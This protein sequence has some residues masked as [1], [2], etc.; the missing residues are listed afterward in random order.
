VYFEDRRRLGELFQLEVG[1]VSCDDKIDIVT[2]PFSSTAGELLSA[3]PAADAT[4]GGLAPLAGPDATIS[5][6]R[7]FTYPLVVRAGLRSARSVILLFHGLNEKSW[8]KYLPWAKEL[9]LRT[10]K[11]V[12]LFPIAFHMNR[13]PGEWSNPRLMARVA[14]ERQRRFGPLTDSSFVNAALSTR[15]QSAPDRFLRSG[16]ATYYD[17]AK[18]ATEIRAGQHPLIDRGATLDIF[19]YSIGAFLAEVLL[20]A[21]PEG[22]FGESKAFLFCGGA[23]LSGMTPV[24]RF[25][26]DSRAEEALSSFFTD[27]FETELSG[28]T[29][30]S[31]LFERIQALGTVFKSLLD[32]D[33]L[34]AFRDRQ[35]QS[36]GRRLAAV[37][38]A[39]D[40]VIPGN[41]IARTLSGSSGTATEGGVWPRAH[42]LDFPF[43]YSHE[44]PFPLLAQFRAEIERSFEG[45]FRLAADFLA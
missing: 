21:N 8:A 19:G 15:I 10:G 14:A 1:R 35:L 28:D 3:W 33:R 26:M 27:R 2:L 7:R 40:R 44:N 6:N 43:P 13:A 42:V 29:P 23:T 4:D 41:E 39:K 18:L 20:F 17:I 24:S 22:H 25:I 37:A 38:L 16:L 34:K 36:I 30:L 5:E 11:A 31:R 32:A 45:L 12:L 9:A